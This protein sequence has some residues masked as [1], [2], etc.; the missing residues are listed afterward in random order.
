MT[1]FS[2]WH[3]LLPFVRPR[4]PHALTG[5]APVEKSLSMFTNMVKDK[6]HVRA[7]QAPLMPKTG[8]RVCLT[9]LGPLDYAISVK[10]ALV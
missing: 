6:V 4:C 5:E 8:V 9:T 2:F 10:G 1:Y 7:R 3:G